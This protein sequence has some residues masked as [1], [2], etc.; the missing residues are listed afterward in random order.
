MIIGILIRGIEI[1]F[2]LL[3]LALFL[4]VLLPWFKVAPENALLRFV[5]ALT[6]P[7]VRPVRRW[8]GGGLAWVTGM[9]PMDFAPVVA[10]M[11]LWLV[12]M[13]LVRLLLMIAAPPVWLLHPGADPAR[14][15]TGVLGWLFQLY[16]F[17]L[18]ARVALDWIRIPRAQGL[19]DFLR[20]ITEPL[21]AP[22]RRLLPRWGGLDFS[23][24]AAVLLLS[25]LQMLLQGVILALF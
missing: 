3:A 8:I 25:L 18:L 22:L 11:L 23:P 21:L 20:R 2:A 15:L 24:V 19:L 9:G 7:L 16:S 4:R 10:F 12:Q 1:V 14:W 13:L 6:E 5:T 17:M